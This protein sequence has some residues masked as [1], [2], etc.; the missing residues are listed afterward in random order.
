[1]KNKNLTSELLAIEGV[2]KA[3]AEKL[4]SHFKS[5]N[6]IKNATKEEL[7][8]VKGIS[9]KTAENIYNYFYIK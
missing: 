2:G 3:S 1:M 4:L 6:K 5:I 7:L 8:S 9:K